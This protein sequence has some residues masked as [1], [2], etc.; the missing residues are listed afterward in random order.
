MAGQLD[1]KNRFDTEMTQTALATVPEAEHGASQQYVAIAA[2][3]QSIVPAR[4]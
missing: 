2:R 1:G 4:L 3:P